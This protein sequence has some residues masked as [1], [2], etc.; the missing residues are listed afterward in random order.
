MR[1][2]GLC[3]LLLELAAEFSE[4]DSDLVYFAANYMFSRLEGL[5]GLLWDGIGERPGSREE[6]K[7]RK[8]TRRRIIKI[9]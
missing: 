9:A 4:F 6:G 8:K 2:P 5:A 3:F 7:R 1:P